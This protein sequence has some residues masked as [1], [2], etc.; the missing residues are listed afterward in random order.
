MK[1]TPKKIRERETDDS[2]FGLLSAYKPVNTYFR[3]FLNESKKQILFEMTDNPKYFSLLEDDL[4]KGF[5]MFRRSEMGFNKLSVKYLSPE[6][7][8]GYFGENL[9]VKIPRRG[10]KIV[11]RLKESERLYLLETSLAQSSSL[12]AVIKKIL[13]LSPQKKYEIIEKYLS[14]TMRPDIEE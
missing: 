8:L 11:N 6:H 10:G 3:M 5:R 2:L 1:I 13:L 12:L 4:L 9:S 7:I 14:S